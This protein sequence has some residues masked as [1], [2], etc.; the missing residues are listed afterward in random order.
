MCFSTVSNTIIN[1]NGKSRYG[2][3]CNSFG[4]GGFSPSCFGYGFNTCSGNP[5]MFGAGVGLGCAVGMAALPVLPS[6]F[7]G[8]GKGCSWLWN[9]AIVPAFKGIG[10]GCSWLW[11]KAIKPAG[12]AIGKGIASAAKWVGNGIKNVWNSIF[13]KKSK[14]S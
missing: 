4:I 13:H 12:V 5:F 10:Q 9:K 2:F 3:G 7:K 11:N 6:I 14:K 1:I 8:I